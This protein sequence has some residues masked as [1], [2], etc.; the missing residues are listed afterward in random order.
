MRSFLGIGFVA[1]LGCF[2]AQPGQ[3]FTLFTC[4]YNYSGKS[5]PDAHDLYVLYDSA[6]NEALGKDGYSYDKSRNPDPVE[7]TVKRHSASELRLVWTVPDVRFDSYSTDLDY[8]ATI[9]PTTGALD[10]TITPVAYPRPWH[11]TGTCTMSKVK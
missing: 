9:N 6:A 4:D 11:F 7:I 1:A 8:L 3:A 2:L 5:K 10:I